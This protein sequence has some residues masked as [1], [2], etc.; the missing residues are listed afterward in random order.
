MLIWLSIHA[1]S[2]MLH[3]KGITIQQRHQCHRQG[4]YKANKVG[5]VSMG[6][7]ADKGAGRSGRGPLNGA[8]PFLMT[9]GARYNALM[10]KVL[11]P[12]T[13]DMWLLGGCPIRLGV[14]ALGRA[15]A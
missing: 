4:M 9:L 15:V 8:L 14:R 11:C 13:I 1:Y 5:W 10:P 2:G 7:W 6:G 12:L 3:S